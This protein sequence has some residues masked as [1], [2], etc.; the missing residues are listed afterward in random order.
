MQLNL[1]RWF[2]L[3][4]QKMVEE[5][6][7]AEPPLRKVAAVA[8]VE[9]PYVGKFVEDLSPLIKASAALGQYL[10]KQAVEAIKPLSIQSYGKGA[11]VGIGG[12]QEHANA[13]ITTTFAEPLRAACGGGRAWISSFTK[14]AP[15][16]VTIDIPLA[17][18]DALYVRS[19]YD[20]M[21][22]TL[23]DAPL[24]DEIAVIVCVANRGRIAARSGGLKAEEVK[25]SD[26]LR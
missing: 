17:H 13:L 4:D 23:P 10:A 25:G 7:L 22:I 19:H 26:G 21:T 2:T 1:R 8:I 16:G 20:G 18:K 12:S 14:L 11:V 24:P 15:P 3:V 5:G 9:N 6:K